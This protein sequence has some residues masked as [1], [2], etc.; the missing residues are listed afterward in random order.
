MRENRLVIKDALIAELCRLA[1]AGAGGQASNISRTI[2]REQIKS[3][4]GQD[5]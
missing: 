1:V 3:R 2:I 5:A 4:A